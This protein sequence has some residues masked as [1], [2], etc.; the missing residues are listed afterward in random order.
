MVQDF[1]NVDL[2][3]GPWIKV[4]AEWVRLDGERPQER[5]EARERYYG[6]DTGCVGWHAV[7]VNGDEEKELTGFV[8]GVDAVVEAVEKLELNLPVVVTKPWL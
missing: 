6:C 7:L 4:A 1:Q 3:D 5:I 2:S 8:W